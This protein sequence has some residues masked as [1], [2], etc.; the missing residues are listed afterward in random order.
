M[1]CLLLFA[2]QLANTSR[3]RKGCLLLG[4]QYAS[5]LLPTYRVY[6]IYCLLFQSYRAKYMRVQFLPD[7]VSYW[8]AI[9][10]ICKLSHNY[11]KR[12]QYSNLFINQT[13]NR[14]HF[15]QD[16]FLWNK[17]WLRTSKELLWWPTNYQMNYQ[18]NDYDRSN[19][20]KHTTMISLMD[21]I[22]SRS[23]Q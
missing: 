6:K 12:N 16:L 5:R 13:V 14:I 18:H 21:K 9:K 11:L 15:K 7:I 22:I 10:S 1:G 20:W 23:K 2:N 17:I 3:L 4:T 8:Y 19:E